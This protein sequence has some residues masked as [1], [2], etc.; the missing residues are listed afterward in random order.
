MTEYETDLKELA[1]FV[2]EMA[3]FEEYLCL[4]FEEGLNLKIREK[5]SIFGNQNYKEVVQLALRVKKLANERMTKEK[6]QK[7]K[8]F[9]FMSGQSSEKSRSFES[10]SNSFRSGAKFVS[11]PQ[12]F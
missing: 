4:K 7:R 10:S 6:F 2:P 11:S 12:A 5:M 9:G 3:G 1:E 8:G